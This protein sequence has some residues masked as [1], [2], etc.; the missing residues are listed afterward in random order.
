[1]NIICMQ[2]K[3]SEKIFILRSNTLDHV[4]VFLFFAFFQE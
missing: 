4:S 2:A 1:M 3:I